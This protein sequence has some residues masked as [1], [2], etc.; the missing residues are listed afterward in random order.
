M[1]S[2]VPP[3]AECEFDN[4]VQAIMKIGL[5]QDLPVFPEGISKELEEFIKCCLRREQ[6]VR[7]S[8]QELINHPFLN[9]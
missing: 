6:S 4:P 1:C 7:L 8:A 5:S 2:G 3:W 9:Y